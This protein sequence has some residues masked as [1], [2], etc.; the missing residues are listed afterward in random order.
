MNEQLRWNWIEGVFNRI[1][2]AYPILSLIVAILIFFIYFIFIIKIWGLHYNI[3]LPVIFLSAFIAYMLAGNQYIID[4]MRY[5]FKELKYI[6]NKEKCGEELCRILE[7]NLVKPNS[8]YLLMFI[9]I[10]LFI[11]KDFLEVYIL[12]SAT[13]EERFFSNQI[14]NVYNYIIFFFSLY[15]LTNMIWI[16]LNVTSIIRIM[17][18]EPYEGVIK[19]DLFNADKVGGL[20]QIRKFIIYMTIYYS[21]GI[22]LAVLAYINPSGFRMVYFEIACLILLLTAGIIILISGLQELQKLFQRKVYKELIEINEKYQELYGQLIKIG[23]DEKNEKNENELEF[24]STSMELLK[25]ERSERESLLEDNARKYNLAAVF[26][27]FNSFAMVLISLYEKLNNF[28]IIKF[29][30]SAFN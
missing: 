11:L 19:I 18:K 9:V 6:P 25:K 2:I 8:F 30:L 27:A 29:I 1:P 5:T 10:S 7:E 13:Y 3:F 21:T 26:A 4:K 23:S 20:G 28:G 17:A 16:V 15:L 12:E 22:S 14:F 24:I